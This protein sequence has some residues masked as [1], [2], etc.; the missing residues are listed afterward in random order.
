[1]VLCPLVPLHATQTSGSSPLPR[2]NES[3]AGTSPGLRHQTARGL[4]QRPPSTGTPAAAPPARAPAAAPPQ[5]A[6]YA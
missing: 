4:A 1:V 5:R 6:L 3:S 2:G